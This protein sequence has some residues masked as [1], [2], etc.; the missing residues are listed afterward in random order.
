MTGAARLLTRSRTVARHAACRAAPLEEPEGSSGGV[1]PRKHSLV[2]HLMVSNH[3][4]PDMVIARHRFPGSPCC[5]N[6]LYTVQRRSNVNYNLVNLEVARLPGRTRCR[7]VGRLPR[8]PESGAG[9]GPPPRGRFV[10]GGV[11]G[12][13]S[14]ATGGATRVRYARRFRGSGGSTRAPV[15]S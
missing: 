14:G 11:G 9:V 2:N 3:K 13:R 10:S 1:L 8:P 6:N 15:G 12:R 7:R 5:N 4:L